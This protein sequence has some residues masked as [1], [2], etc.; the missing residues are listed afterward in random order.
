MKY[1][2]NYYS[3]RNRKFNEFHI[4]EPHISETLT[5]SEDKRETA[6]NSENPSSDFRYVV[7]WQLH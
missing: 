3:K 4:P 5:R 6:R 2:M 7:P 1:S